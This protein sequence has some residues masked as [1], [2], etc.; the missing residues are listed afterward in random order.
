MM[1]RVDRL[2]LVLLAALATAACD[3][4]TVLTGPDAEAAVEQFQAE[5]NAEADAAAD[6]RRPVIVLDGERI[7]EPTEALLKSIEPQDIERI[8]VLKGCRALAKLGE[9]ATSGAI[10]IYT[11]S[12]D[13][14]SVEFDDTEEAWIDACIEE[15]RLRR[16][17]RVGR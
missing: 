10:Y 1:W 2:A 13:G 15:N 14:P 4:H 5:A 12:Y 11:K 17:A 3:D 8:E 6:E 9:D 16:R 7:D